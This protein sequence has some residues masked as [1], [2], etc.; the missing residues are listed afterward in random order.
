MRIEKFV[1]G[2]GE[3]YFDA[4]NGFAA[5]REDGPA[6]VWK[7]GKKEWLKNDKRHRVDGPAIEKPD[8]FKSYFYEGKYYPDIKTDDEWIALV[9]TL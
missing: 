2:D 4:E 7:N 1:N 8:G 9:K 6:M 3:Y 5:H